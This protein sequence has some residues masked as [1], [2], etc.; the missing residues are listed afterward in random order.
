MSDYKIPPITTIE[1]RTS[2][3]PHKD[4]PNNYRTWVNVIQ[5]YECVNGL[6]KEVNDCYIQHIRQPDGTFDHIY[7][8]KDPKNA[9]LLWT[10]DQ[11]KYSFNLNFHEYSYEFDKKFK[12]AIKYL[13]EHGFLKRNDESGISTQNNQ[14]NRNLGH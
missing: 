4:A 7:H 2:Q 5:H 13:N 14:D 1:G 12:G 11:R 9:V 6:A 8:V 3:Q 10:E